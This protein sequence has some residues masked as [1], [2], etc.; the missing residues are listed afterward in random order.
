MGTDIDAIMNSDISQP[1]AAASPR[2]TVVPFYILTI[3]IRYSST[4]LGKRLH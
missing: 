3:L 1:L 2:F 4:A